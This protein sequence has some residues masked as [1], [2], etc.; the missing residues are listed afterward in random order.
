MLAIAIGIVGAGAVLDAWALVRRATREGFLATNPASATLRTERIDSALLARVRAVPG[1]GAVAA[2]RTVV[3]AALT[4]VGWQ[5]AVLFAIRD[6]AALAIG[7]IAPVAGV[8]PPR[9]SAFVVESSSVEF[10]GL[11]V[12]GA[13]TLRAGDHPPLSFPVAGIARD[14]GLAP[15]WMEH[16]VYGFVPPSVLAALG[17][18]ADFDD[19]QILVADRS[20][21]RE[22][23]RRIAADV[24]RLVVSTGRVVREVTVPE[25]GKHIHAGQ[26]NSLLFTQ[27]AFGVL[28]LLLSGFLVVNL[29]TAM[30]TGQV[31]EIGIMKA[32]GARSEQ[33]TAM[34]LGLAFGLGLA[35]CLVAVPAAALIGRWYAG[36]TA[37]LLNFDTAPYAI[38]GWALALQVAAGALLPVAAAAMP[39]M[40]GSRLSVSEA[41]RDVGL[42]TTARPPGLLLERTGGL[43]RPVLLS[44]RNAFRR[45]QRMILTLLTLA[46]GGAVYLGALN[47]RAAI[48]ASIADLYGGRMRFDLSVRLVEPL[49]PDTIE[50]R[51]A[52]MPGVASAEAWGGRSAAVEHADGGTGSSFGL[53]L[54]PVRSRMI[55]LP[56]VAGRWL[57]PGDRNAIVVTR[58]LAEDEPALAVGKSIALIIGGRRTEWTVVGMAGGVPGGGAYGPREAMMGVFGDSRTAAAMVIATD[59]SP[60]AQAALSRRIRERLDAGG[61]R[62]AA[63]QLMAET[64]RVMED[65]LL[66]VAGFLMVMSQLMIVVGGLGLASTMSLAVLERT[67]EIGVLRA[68][69]ARHRTILAIVQ[70]EG[71]VIGLLSWA[72]AIPLSIPASVYLGQVFGRIMIPVPVRLVPEGAGVLQWL[73]VVVVVSLAASAWPA[74]RATRI[75]TAAALAYE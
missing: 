56:L 15:G 51:F 39:V 70:V 61:M 40:R 54:V 72:I 7:T 26:I 20:V 71:L 68:I 32:L 45:R 23:I 10:S 36:F 52:A 69:G 17:A 42:D 60:L 25:P 73:V 50:A 12:G 74:I 24:R 9:D 37:Q 6:P 31:R 62:V 5:T 48:K 2:R 49:P 29:I 18:P 19:L 11:A 21:D 75:T 66:M 30:L 65:H 38:P 53:T 57:V 8:W 27:G 67:R 14:A 58:T 55:D 43:T 47:L 46:T 28:A 22:S 33:L 59:R 64:R 41:L 1:I 63:S 13:V 3:A 4:E 34:Y 44:L 16:I 35:A